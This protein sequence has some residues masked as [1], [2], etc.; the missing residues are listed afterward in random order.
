MI[1]TSFLISQLRTS[2][3]YVSQFLTMETNPFW[4]LSPQT[5]PLNTCCSINFKR[6]GKLGEILN[7]PNNC[8]LNFEMF[9]RQQLKRFDWDIISLGTKSIGLV[10]VFSFYFL[11]HCNNLKLSK[12]L[13]SNGMLIEEFCIH[14]FGFYSCRFW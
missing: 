12:K 13:Y 4:L 2:A 6:N 1:L 14:L 8:V 11:I 3:L 9:W 5:M 7:S 10:I